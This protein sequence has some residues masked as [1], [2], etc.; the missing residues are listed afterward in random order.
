MSSVPPLKDCTVPETSTVG[1]LPDCATAGRDSRGMSAATAINTNI[2]RRIKPSFAS[3]ISAQVGGSQELG[4]LTTPNG[5]L[6]RIRDF[7]QRRLAPSPPEKRNPHRQSAHK[8][9]GHVDVRISGHRGQRR[10]PSG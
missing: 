5:L 2:I 1:A 6:K 3:G 10:T 7:D 4:R 9:H 8:S